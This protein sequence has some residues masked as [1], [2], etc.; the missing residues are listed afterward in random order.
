MGLQGLWRWLCGELS[1]AGVTSVLFSLKTRL[2]RSPRTLEDLR[3]FI[4][5]AFAEIHQNK[6][7]CAQSQQHSYKSS[8]KNE[9]VRA[10]RIVPPI[11]STAS[12][13]V[14]D[15]VLRTLLYFALF[16]SLDYFVFSDSSWNIMSSTKTGEMS[17]QEEI[18]LLGGD[19]PPASIGD[20]GNPGSGDSSI[21]GMLVPLM[22]RISESLDAPSALNPRAEASIAE[23]HGHA[24]HA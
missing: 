15:H 1:A 14:S 2:A 9:G 8:G 18:A 17:E 5:N 13:S 22:A 11:N 24:P 10:S 20:Q 7:L 3:D 21:L 4:T 12:C 23:R 6:E 19:A 16:Y